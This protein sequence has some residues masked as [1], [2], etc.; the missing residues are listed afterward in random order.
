MGGVFL[1]ERL[2]PNDPLRFL[3]AL[4]EHGHVIEPGPPL[5]YDEDMLEA[6]GVA[7][8]HAATFTGWFGHD[9]AEIALSIVEDHGARVVRCA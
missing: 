7:F 8:H 2:N 6:I 5:P 4:A 1:D 9:D 3:E